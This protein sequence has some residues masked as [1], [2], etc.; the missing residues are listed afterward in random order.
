M[1]KSIAIVCAFALICAVLCGCG[2][3]RA[4]GKPA[5]ES[6][7]PAVTVT[8]EITPMPTPDV[9][10]GIVKDKDGVIEDRDTGSAGTGGTAAPTA[11][12]KPA[13]TAKP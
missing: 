11:S 3:M 4:D 9:N 1:K 12:P 6:P 2:E 7:A 8:P 13:A 10:D 5:Y